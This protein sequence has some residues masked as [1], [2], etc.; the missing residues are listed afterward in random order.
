[1]MH[2]WKL[3]DKFDFMPEEIK[4]KEFLLSDEYGMVHVG[5]TPFD[6]YDA[7]YW[8]PMPKYPIGAPFITN[9]DAIRGLLKD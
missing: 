6:Y 1:M 9:D 2:E 7:M 4:G 3:I 5:S 8:C